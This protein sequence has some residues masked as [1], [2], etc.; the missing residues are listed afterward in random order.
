MEYKDVKFLE[1]M[2]KDHSSAIV[3]RLCS[4]NELIKASSLNVDQKLDT[5][6]AFNRELIYEEF[7]N[8]LSFVKCYNKG[9]EY[10]KF[11]VYK[12]TGRKT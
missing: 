10:E 1:K 3:G 7:R 5:L 2:L 6:K 11:D 8:I 9:V 4:Q 12:P